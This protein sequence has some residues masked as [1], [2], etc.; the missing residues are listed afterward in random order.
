MQRHRIRVELTDRPGALARVAAV[1][2]SVGANIVSVDVHEVDGVTAIDELVIEA[3]TRIDFDALGTQLDTR[4][5]AVLL[6]HQRRDEELDPVTEALKQATTLVAAE[7][8]QRDE[9]LRQ[10]I[11]RI[12]V[13]SQSWTCDAEDARMV[14][15]G[16]RALERERAVIHKSDLPVAG[17]TSD[18]PSRVW[19]LA[20]PYGAGSEERVAFVARPL[21]L[22]FSASE[23]AR[24]EALVSLRDRIVRTIE[25]ARRSPNVDLLAS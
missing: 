15:A 18:T 1:I 3:P 10:A 19:L 17:L 25:M 11:L 24:V 12:C 2:A 4:A 22:R 23:I 13:C 5:G 20:V 7:P 6:S 9:E 8:D 21:S 14:A 16:L